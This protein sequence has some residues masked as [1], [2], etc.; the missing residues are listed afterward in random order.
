MIVIILTLSPYSIPNRNA[1][2][3]KGGKKL[4]KTKEAS[5]EFYVFSHFSHFSGVWLLVTLW[6]I[7]HQAL[8]SMR[9]SRQKYWGG[10]PY[11]PPG[12]PP[13]PGIKA[14]SLALQTDSLP[15]W[16]PGKP[17]EFWSLPI[18]LHLDHTLVSEQDF[19][20]PTDLTILCLKYFWT[21]TVSQTFYI[22]QRQ[23]TKQRRGKELR[24]QSERKKTIKTLQ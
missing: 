24:K 22:Y 11:L 5:D 18:K 13:N 4:Y 9:L 16:P 10:F 2:R 1:S 19:L 6:T 12:G 3:Q 8:L 20:M 7:A 15:T 14:V 23:E 21:V 17:K